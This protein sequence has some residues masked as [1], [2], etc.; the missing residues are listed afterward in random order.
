VSI[1]RRRE[2]LTAPLE[3]GEQKGDTDFAHIRGPGIL[4]AVA[5][6]P[7]G[8][9]LIATSLM[10]AKPVIIWNTTDWIA[11]TESG[12][13]SA[14]LS[15]D[16]KLLALGGRNH[17]KVI[18]QASRKEIRNIE[19]PEMTRGEVTRNNEKEPNEKEKIP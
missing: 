19:L 7:D 2:R 9:T 5:F 8:N 10:A 13:N 1:I 6:S 15:K 12:D 11:E 17:I 4:S 18:E 14:A 16:G 3:F